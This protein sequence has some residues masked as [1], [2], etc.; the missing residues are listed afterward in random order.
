[1]NKVLQTFKKVVGNWGALELVLAVILL[2]WSL[3]YMGLR[4]VQEWEG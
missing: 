3:L 2:P 1:M 4:M